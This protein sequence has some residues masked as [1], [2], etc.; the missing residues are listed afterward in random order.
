[1]LD[2][3]KLSP[4]KDITA[5]DGYNYFSSLGGFPMTDEKLMRE[6]EELNR[7]YHLGV[8]QPKKFEFYLFDI[9]DD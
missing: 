7:R 2:K 9:L 3:K 1:M 4:E 8:F 6:L 5:Q